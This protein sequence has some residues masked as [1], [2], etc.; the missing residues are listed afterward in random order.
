MSEATST[1]ASL[2]VASASESVPALTRVPFRW[3]HRDQATLPVER[4][5]TLPAWLHGQLVRTAPAVFERNGWRAA[6]WFDGL[7]LMYGFTFEGEHVTFRQR[8]LASHAAAMAATGKNKLGS[9]GTP[10]QRNLLQRMFQPAPPLTD[11]TNVNVVPWQGAWLAMTETA[12]QQVVD[13]ATME[14]RGLYQYVDK[15]SPRLLTAHPH[16][17]FDGDAMVNLGTSFGRKSEVSVFRQG[18]RDKGRTREGGLSFDAVPYVHDFG[19]TARHLV[20]IDHP[21]RLKPITLLFSNR[22]IVDHFKWEPETGTRLWKFDRKA[23]TWRA[24]ETDTLFCFHVVNTFEEG[25]DVV[26]DF[27]AFDDPS[28]LPKL[29]TEVLARGVLPTF[30]PRYVRARLR[31]DAKRAELEELSDVRF[32]FPSIPY[33]RQHGRPYDVAWGASIA[34]APSGEWETQVVRIDLAHRET[35]SYGERGVLYGEPVF[36]PKPDADDPTEGVLLSVGAHLHE[37]RTTLAVIDAESMRPLAHCDVGLSLP[38]SFHGNF[39]AAR[40]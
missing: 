28:I 15:L 12:N 25:D 30:A 35:R 19:L 3:T 39:Q 1:I 37:E 40:R 18:P 8:L 29:R 6:H 2:R 5:G 33:R 31:P 7:A 4:R 24:Y 13:G 23:A 22:P 27:L 36:V 34:A 9:F 17:D 20:L 16:Y 38:A 26:F 10:L 21:F 14:A 11:N 32:E